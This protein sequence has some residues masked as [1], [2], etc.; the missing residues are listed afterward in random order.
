MSTNPVPLST[1]D[2]AGPPRVGPVRVAIVEFDE[3]GITVSANMRLSG[4]GAEVRALL[5]S[6]PEERRVDVLES[7]LLVGLTTLSAASHIHA[8]DAVHIKLA[9]AADRVAEAAGQLGKDYHAHSKE[10]SAQ[11]NTMLREVGKT[12]ASDRELENRARRELR[13]H[14]TELGKAAKALDVSRAELETRTQRLLNGLFKAQADAK[15]AMLK[16]VDAMLRRLVD[17]TDPASAPRIVRGVVETATNEMRVSTEKN[18][19]ELETGVRELLGEKSPFANHIAKVA[20]EGSER[21]LKNVLEILGKL[22][23]DMLVARTREAHDPSVKGPA[24]ED[25]VLALVAPAAA[26]FELTVEPTGN[27][28]GE[29]A[30]SKKGDLVLCD[31]EQRP[32]AALEARARKNVSQ[33]ELLKELGATAANRGVEVVAY[34]VQSAEHLPNGIGEFSC[35]QMPCSHKQLP[36]G[37]HA[38][39]AVVDPEA[40]AIAERVALIVWLVTRM[41]RSVATHTGAGDV[42]RTLLEALPHVERLITNLGLFRGIKGGLTKASGQIESVREA[43][44]R[45]ENLLRV[46]VE[47]LQQALGGHGVVGGQE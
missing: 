31:G 11:I 25:A 27:Q 22:R 35:G 30:N 1:A 29:T 23:D 28:A 42:A 15:D 43:V 47:A 46:D 38:L 45:C 37:V 44:E 6:T 2:A 7:G 41:A 13:T 3:L 12:L 26:V 4:V 16:N 14:A 8:A 10:L 24:Y 5:E 36:G 39:I 21:D 32:V 34:V 20:R 40:P 18:V 19:K 9:D 33:R 17:E